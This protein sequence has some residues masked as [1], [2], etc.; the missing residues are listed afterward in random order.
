V[1]LHRFRVIARHVEL[2]GFV[3]GVPTPGARDAHPDDYWNVIVHAG[4]RDTARGWCHEW[5]SGAI[6]EKCAGPTVRQP[7]IAMPVPEV[8]REDSLI[9]GLRHR[10]YR[11]R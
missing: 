8:R 1:L 3:L 9:A 10:N 6:L 4:K 2:E 5:I 7:C 11:P